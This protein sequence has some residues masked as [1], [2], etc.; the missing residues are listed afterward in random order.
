MKKNYEKNILMIYMVII[1][2]VFEVMM[3]SLYFKKMYRTYCV[4]DAFMICDNYIKMYVDNDTMKTIRSSSI[5][6]I[7][8]KLH[9]Y[10]VVNIESDVITKNNKKY[11]GVIIQTK[12]PNKYKDNDAILISIFTRKEKIYNIL[13]KCW[14]SD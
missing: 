7:D 6:Y 5:F 10:K 8:D 4:I 3:I 2:I 1:F 11:Y 9:K 13:K 14:E 12:I